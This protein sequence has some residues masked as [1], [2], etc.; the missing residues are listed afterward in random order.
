[1][2]LRDIKNEAEQ[3]HVCSK[4]ETEQN[5]YEECHSICP[6]L[7]LAVSTC[8]KYILFTIGAE[9][10]WQSTGWNVEPDLQPQL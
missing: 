1:M 3:Q 8:P 5:K 9:I 6:F 4:I 7:G 10:M 2:W